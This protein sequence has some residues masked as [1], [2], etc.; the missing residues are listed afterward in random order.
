MIIDCHTHINCPGGTIGPEEHFAES[1]QVD[2]CFVLA[3]PDEP[4]RQSNKTVSE[5]ILRHTDK[6]FGFAVINP[7]VDDIS[8]RYWSTMKNDM[9]FKGVVLYCS[10]QGFHP[11]HSLALQFYEVAQ[12]LRL[13]LFFHNS[14][15]Y[16]ADAVLE[17]ARPSLLDEIARNFKDLKIVIGS[18]GQPF[19]NETMCMLEKHENVYGDLTIN[20]QKVWGVY[21]TVL[22]AHEAG[23]LG[24][25]IFGSGLPY[26]KPQSCIE[27]LLG[28]NKLLADVNLP[29]VPRE[30]IREIIE[31]DSLALLGIQH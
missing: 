24:K 26:C 8:K 27:T 7:V 21:N 3:C 2:G 18:M 5:Y 23:V 28:F 13:P 14:G 11:A 31:R 30:K 9:G 6:M 29:T 22:A 10:H 4:N 1:G 17:Y 20:P 12:E 15:P 16:D 25:L 19:T